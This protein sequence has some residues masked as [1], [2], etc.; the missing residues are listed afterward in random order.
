MRER[1]E[2]VNGQLELTNAG[3]GGALVRL[4]VPASPEVR[5]AAE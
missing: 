2:L 3:A 5:R 4:R 1:S